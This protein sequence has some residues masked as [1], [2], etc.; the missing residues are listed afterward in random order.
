MAL[1][2]LA[3]NGDGLGHLV[4]TT[5]VCR[6]LESVG[7]RPV[8]FSQGIFP[9]DDVVR[10]PGTH[11]P[12]LWRADE[13]V[14][15]RVASD[16][17]SMTEISAPAVLV[18]DTHPNPIA[19]PANTRRVLL[20]RPTTFEYLSL[21]NERYGSVYSAF[22]LCDAPDSPTWPY[23]AAQTEA[24]LRWSRWHVIGPVYRAGTESDLAA[25]RE[26]YALEGGQRLCVFSM[27]GGGQLHPTDLDAERFVAFS[28]EVAKKLKD[29]DPDTRL[30]FVRGPYFPPT[31]RIDGCFEV[32]A[33]EPR[34]PALLAL[35][36]G[37]VIRTGFNTTWECLAGGTPFW[38]FLG[39]TYEE[40]TAERLSRLRNCGLLADDLDMF[41][42]N[43]R[44]R[45][46][47]RRSSL[48]GRAVAWDARGARLQRLIMD[49]PPNREPRAGGLQRDRRF[50]A[51]DRVY[52]A[53]RRFRLGRSIPLAIRVD[54]VISLDSTLV[55][56]LRLLSSHRW[57]A[58]LEV[59]PYLFDFDETAL[60]AFDP[61]RDLFEVSQ[62]G[63]AHVP[64]SRPD[65]RR[66][67]FDPDS[68]A[69]D[70]RDRDDIGWGKERLEQVFPAR[71]SGG[72]SPPFDG[73]PGWLPTVWADR[74]GTF[75]SSMFT[76]RLESSPI[77]VIRAGVDVWNWSQNRARE[78]HEILRGVER[79]AKQD[80]H[81][82][83][84]LHTH[85]LQG[86][87]DR[88]RL[89]WLLE[90]LH[91]R[92]FRAASLRELA[93]TGGAAVPRPSLWR[94]LSAMIAWPSGRSSRRAGS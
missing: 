80:G 50:V 84:I 30:I 36:D 65:G 47:F 44:R 88:A 33:Q 39:T 45:E 46:E 61:A 87:F 76:G 10:L 14:R 40:P 66:Y 43:T 19:M 69:P 60:D 34:M 27:G 94:S 54:D 92:G 9:L 29:D 11:V 59:V 52:G 68:P 28:S 15:R 75:V 72:F 13:S 24:V 26:R 2:F 6:A 32:V 49:C 18:E 77:P 35:A 7:E 91:T 41:V 63:Y 23:S 42:K 57:Q 48:D 73:F 90:L 74:G 86:R 81:A 31:V 93:V 1:A 38:P 17:R 56:L 70:A 16:L 67:E 83:L 8:I 79:Q 22:L 51:G 4:R 53:S 64:R 58:S 85:R 3:L 5:I 55:W 25:V 71:F 78:R 62:H 89:V 21:L 20:V 37:A 12:S 82:G